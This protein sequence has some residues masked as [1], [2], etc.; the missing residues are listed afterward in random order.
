MFLLSIV[1]LLPYV[2]FTPN[3]SKDFYVT[4]NFQLHTL[5]IK[6]VISLLLLVPY[7]FFYQKKKVNSTV[8]AYPQSG[9]SK[10]LQ[11]DLEDLSL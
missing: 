7:R 11:K 5:N 10:S 3:S 8:K 1:S 4:T 2:K 6:K 9:R